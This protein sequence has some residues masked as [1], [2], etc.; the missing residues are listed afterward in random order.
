MRLV[1]TVMVRDEADIIE[2]ML[3]HH[4]DQGVDEILVT[5]NGSVDGT[6]EILAGL[7]RGGGDHRFEFRGIAAVERHAA[8]G[9][10]TLGSK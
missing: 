10:A 1:M 6:R 2:S 4:L 8:Y 3:L 9:A 7:E 5:D